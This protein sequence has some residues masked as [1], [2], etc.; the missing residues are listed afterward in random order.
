M[1]TPR[2]EFW[3]YGPALDLLFGPFVNYN[4]LLLEID[5]LEKDSGFAS[6]RP[7]STVL[8]GHPNPVNLWEC[9]APSMSTALLSVVSR[10]RNA[11]TYSTIPR[12][13]TCTWRNQPVPEDVT[14][15]RTPRV[16]SSSMSGLSH[17]HVYL[18]SATPPQLTP[19]NLM[20]I[21]TSFQQTRHSA[22]WKSE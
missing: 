7:A 5:D 3:V 2:T 4:K 1:T 9:V 21:N 19:V 12:N 16:L 17:T 10:P 14:Q 11:C 20:Y 6:D 8:S 18:T 15:P 13:C 22:S